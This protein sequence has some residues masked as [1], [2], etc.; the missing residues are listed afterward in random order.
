LDLREY[1]ELWKREFKKELSLHRKVHDS[2]AK[3]PENELDELFDLAISEGIPK[4]I[5]DYGD[6]DKVSTLAK[7][8]LG[9]PRL[10]SKLAKYITL[11]PL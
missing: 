4:L 5:E 10:L 6:M 7:H 2:M 9:K 3:I 1:D 8:L 11:I